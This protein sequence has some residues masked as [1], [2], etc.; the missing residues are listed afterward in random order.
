M[1]VL[2]IAKHFE[3][4]SLVI[5]YNCPIAQVAGHEGEGHISAAYTNQWDD[6][7][8]GVDLWIFGHTHEAVDVTIGGCR[9]VSNPLGYPGETTGFDAQ[10]VVEI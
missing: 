10:K 1:L 5:T 2:A 8:P 3:G 7:V 4:L 9:F 6:L